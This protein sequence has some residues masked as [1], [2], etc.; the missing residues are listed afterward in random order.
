MFKVNE[1]RRGREKGKKVFSIIL[2]DDEETDNRLADLG[3]N[4]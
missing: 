1:Q 4:D 2:N 3:I